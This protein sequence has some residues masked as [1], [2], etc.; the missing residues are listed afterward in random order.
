M[1]KK[2]EAPGMLLPEIDDATRRE[3]LIGAAGLL[4]LPVA[5][6]SD[7]ESGGDTSSETRTVTDAGGEEVRIPASP[8]RLAVAGERVLTEMAIS[9][10]FEPVA[11]AAK[12][13][14]APF[15]V[16]AL[17]EGFGD[18]RSLGTAGE[19]NVEALAAAEPDLILVD[20]YEGN[21]VFEQVREVA[22]T[23]QMLTYVGPRELIASFG[24]VFGE[25]KAGELNT[26]L[27]KGI[28]RIQSLVEDPGS[29]EVSVA[30]VQEGGIRV[31]PKRTN[32]GTV[33]LDDAGFSRPP[34]Q[35]EVRE[36]NASV[37]LSLEELGEVDGDMLYLERVA[38]DDEAYENLAFGQLWEN[39][40]VV[41]RGAVQ[42]VDY[43]AW[44]L[45][46]PL[47]AEVVFEDVAR[48]LEKAGL[49]R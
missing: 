43:R 27:D 34:G 17:G 12:D 49:A 36:F 19:V 37:Q 28:E 13:E 46:G 25:A 38:G 8:R 24:R 29:V 7:G 44:N 26:R 1:A 39:L 20:F 2:I 23:L 11:V 22:P 45:G 4:L 41:R 9:F 33:L 18:I 30:Q 16:D 47:A 10:S 32:L 21:P 42:E 48:G 40:E 14:F 6:G 15:L 31:W 3:F 5:C 35:R